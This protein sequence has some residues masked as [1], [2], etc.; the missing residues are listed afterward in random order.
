MD[1]AAYLERIGFRGEPRR[2]AEAL[3][4]LHVAH[5]MS[6]P[7]ENLDIQLG[8]EIRLD[9]RLLYDKIVV[10]RRGGYCYELNGMFAW[11]LRSVDFDVT[12]VSAGVYDATEDRFGPDGDHLCLLVRLEHTWLADVGFGASFLEPM[13]LVDAVE[14]SEGSWAY[15]L[16]R[17]DDGWTM[18][19]REGAEA[20]VPQYRFTTRP[21]RLYDFTFANH[22][23]QTS[24]DS[25][26][27]KKRVCTRATPDGRIT[28]SDMRFIET[29]NGAR[30][31]RAVEG[32][33]EYARLL[34]DSFGV[35]LT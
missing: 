20:W 12:L 11:L 24:P 4:R 17:D 6:V 7:F 13:P 8:R 18:S 19:S 23:M 1:R 27:T 2:D 25:I 26:F 34:L 14:R 10:R 3:R 28:I 9:E 30:A 16:T 5:L 21:R 32:N 22:Y 29:T 35:S 33:E 15:R 31:E